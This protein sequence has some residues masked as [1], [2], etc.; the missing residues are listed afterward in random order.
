MT[1]QQVKFFKELAYIQEYCINVRVGKERSPSDIEELLKDMT[2]EVIYR[3]MELL[4]GYGGELP[5]H[6]NIAF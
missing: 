4:D 2:F 6:N 1:N 3:I 5:R